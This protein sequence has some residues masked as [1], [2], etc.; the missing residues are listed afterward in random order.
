MQT[1]PPDQ[2]SSKRR[3][4]D[5][6][7]TGP[8]V[9]R[10]LFSEIPLRGDEGPEDVK[11]TCVDY[12]ESNLY[13]GTSASEILHFFQL[14]AD[15]DDVGAGPT[16]ILASRLQPSG[17]A[18]NPPAQQPR[19]V[20]QIL[21]LPGTSKACVL[22]NGV[23]SFYTLP[24]LSPAFPNKEPTG[25]S[26]IG[27]VDEDQEE[28]EEP[29]LM[30][31]NTKRILLVKVGEKLQSIKK[32]EYSS[33]LRSSRR[34]TIACVA[35]KHAYALL[36]IEHQQKIPLFSISSIAEEHTAALP[37]TSSR[38]AIQ[39]SSLAKQERG[40]LESPGHNRSTSLGNPLTQIVD[41]ASPDSPA[42]TTNLLE[43][44]PAETSRTPSPSKTGTLQ[45]PQDEQF[46]SRPRAST[47]IAVVQKP[48]PPRPSTYEPLI[49][50]PSPTQFLLT[51]GSGQDEPGVGMFVNLDGDV[52]RGT[53]EFERYPVSLALD[54]ASTHGENAS[55]RTREA[56][57]VILALLERQSSS[58]LEIGIE[59]Q[60]LSQ[61]PLIANGSKGWTSF[62]GEQS[63]L[64]AGLLNVLSYCEYN[65]REVSELLQLVR[66]RR[67][68]HSS[69][70][71]P[72]D[73]DPR[74]RSCVERVEEEKALFESNGPDSGM[75]DVSP[76][77]E[78]RRAA[79]EI[80]IAACLGFSRTH[81]I[82]WSK[83]CVWQ[84]QQNPEVL[85]LEA[86]LLAEEVAVS[87]ASH[88]A[89]VF[90]RVRDQ[91]PQSEAEFLSLG[92]IKQKISL[93]TF[94]HMQNA[95]ESG[96][97]EESQIR[98]AENILLE[99]GLDPRVILLLIAPLE[100]EVLQGTQG[101]W[102]HQGLSDLA[103]T[104]SLSGSTMDDFSIEFWMLIRRFLAAWQGKRGYG[105]I[106]DEQLVFDSVDAALLHTL[107]HL[108]KCL[109]PGTGAHTSARAKLNNVV[110]NWKGNFDRAVTLL[111]Q[112]RR[113][114]VLSRLYQSKK[115][116]KDVLG[117]W[118]RIVD[119]E[120]DLG[121]DKSPAEIEIQLRRYL[122]HLRDTKLVEEYSL[123]LA[124]RNSTLAIQFF[125]D[126]SSKV[127][128]SPQQVTAMLKRQAPG[129]VQE[130]L[131][132]LVF[133]KGFHQYADDLIGY[134]LDSVLNVLEH[135][136]NARESLAQSYSTYR[137]LE[138][139]KPTYMGFITQ[140]APQ[141]AWWQARLRLLQLL[142]SGSYATSTTSAK[143][144]TYSIPMVLERLAPYSQYLVS[145]SIILDARQ[146]RHKEALKLLTHGLGDYDT[147]VRYCYFGGPAPASSTTIDADSLPPRESQQELFA[148][149]F[150]EFLVIEDVEARLE[151][152]S[153]LLGTF[154]TYFDP[155]T[156]LDQIPP[157]WGIHMLKDFILRTFRAA[158]SERNQAVIMKA[159]S[160][161][162]NL[163]KQAEFVD[164]CEKMGAKIEGETF[165]ED[166]PGP[167]EITQHLGGLSLPI[168]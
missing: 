141:E 91:E 90:A 118:R 115:M 65:F 151:R 132:H 133:N 56:D 152:T 144:L 137:A 163:Q 68:G 11:I 8:Y 4:L 74:T 77:W 14:P 17:T 166:G 143:E 99:G 108:D 168:Q 55:L 24:E 129:A 102:I 79:E 159:L 149:L 161:A 125:T 16:F 47:E 124:S 82:A 95:L 80:K 94:L 49:I 146:G 67:P 117:T 160:A 127:R 51:T 104:V 22:C 112:Y 78:K 5:S 156:V 107:L 6:S 73:P 147:A 25:V 101:L 43:Q 71:T 69:N 119:G 164:V 27:G 76:E 13:I 106:S 19:G 63:D 154:A 9:L 44:P 162:Q 58:G 3:R 60:S 103:K 116:A 20:R 109:T 142:G 7:E 138:A 130:Y 18:S 52:D 150:T 45:A 122:V 92:Y 70:S 81:V 123:W 110:D 72:P 85:R 134:Y 114:F 86:S 121:G 54:K 1:E 35:D 165:E 96:T 120:P 105:S 89:S 2:R 42:V 38:H 93:M 33:C 61:E 15:P 30:I 126:D 32:I 136:T 97:I 12:W 87:K 39:G 40:G 57:D 23:V 10:K 31:A 75:E 157:D 46:R 37:E 62:G 34:G 48:L 98:I 155:L 131:E 21:L 113:L 50:S 59:S 158:T 100:T 84:V 140:N 41:Q 53:I 128:F 26:W 64:G 83:D 153:H 145:E 28:S 139:P 148:H 66:L 135:N 88:I 167:A 36:E 29:V 111:E